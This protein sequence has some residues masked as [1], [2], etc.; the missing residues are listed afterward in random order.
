MNG[1]AGSEIWAAA[2]SSMDGQHQQTL[3]SSLRSAFRTT[4]PGPIRGGSCVL[5][6]IEAAKRELGSSPHRLPTKSPIPGICTTLR[7]TQLISVAI[8]Y[9]RERDRIKIGRLDDD[10]L[11]VS[12]HPKE[13]ARPGES[14]DQSIRT[15]F[16][17]H[18]GKSRRRCCTPQSV[19]EKSR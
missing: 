2:T 16:H 12:E 18:A 1:C 11:L 8:I 15:N 9:L 4:T 7:G 13:T 17:H 14:R 5:Q 6:I 10:A 19:H 3:A